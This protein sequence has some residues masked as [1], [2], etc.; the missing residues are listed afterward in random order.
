MEGMFFDADSA[1]EALEI[2]VV[3]IADLYQYLGLDLPEDF[4]PEAEFITIIDAIRNKRNAL[5]EP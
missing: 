2:T 3:F 1:E 4:D 5:Q